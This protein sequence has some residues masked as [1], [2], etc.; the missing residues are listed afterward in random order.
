MSYGYRDHH[1]QAPVKTVVDAKADVAAADSALAAF[2][3]TRPRHFILPNDPFW[4]KR[5]QLEIAVNRAKRELKRATVASEQGNVAAAKF[6]AKITLLDPNVTRP[7]IAW[8]VEGLFG[9]G[10]VAMLVAHG[11]SL[12][13]WVAY[14]IARA[15][16][17]GK[18][19]LGQYKVEQG[20]VLI[21]DY[22]VGEDE[23]DRMLKMLAQGDATPIPY[24]WHFGPLSEDATWA[25]IG[26]YV[27][28]HKTKFIVVDSLTGGNPDADQNQTE[29]SAPLRK[30]ALL[31]EEA[32]VT[33]LFIHHE[34]KG[35]GP[36]NEAIRG[37]G[38]LHGDSDAIY[39]N[40]D[41]KVPSTEVRTLKMAVLKP[42]PGRY[43]DPVPLRFSDAGGMQLDSGGSMTGAPQDNDYYRLRQSMQML[44][45][46][47]VE[48]HALIDALK[49]DYKEKDVK[50]QLKDL[51]SGGLA[52]KDSNGKYQAD[53]RVLR[54]VRVV[55]A[56]DRGQSRSSL[57]KYS[58]VK[59]AQIDELVGT[60]LSFGGG[61]YEIMLGVKAPAKDFPADVW[62]ELS[63]RWEWVDAGTSAFFGGDGE[64]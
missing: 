26:H 28:K 54:F 48:E 31:A 64:E 17:T 61:K 56:I 57:T 36:A 12:K 19:W 45:R 49:K 29:F 21:L 53:S 44:V 51:I 35:S 20:G 39:R 2:D 42:G 4:T 10:W 34:R 1:D 41:V 14:S 13:T 16:A 38:S 5:R 22:E 11:S 62:Q 40:V 43:P 25:A 9:R 8:T 32:G 15:V 47:P 7:P 3:A 60:W 23:A 30:A 37:T 27:R 63:T 24:I 46:Q 18:P 59:S 58:H 33:F 50:Q 52:R 6:E 55:K